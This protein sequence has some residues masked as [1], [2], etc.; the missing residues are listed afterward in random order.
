MR[1]LDRYL[2]RELLI[3]LGYCLSG[4]LIFWVSFDLFSELAEFQERRM[5]FREIGEYYVVKLPELLVVVVPIALLLALLY[6]L[7]NHARHNELVA[8]RAA[9]ISLWRLS[10][11][12]LVVGVLFTSAL[13]VVNEVWVPRSAEAVDAILR[14]KGSLKAGA[15][16]WHSNLIFRNARDGRTWSIGRFNLDTFEM[17]SPHVAWELPDGV[18]RS[19]SAATA[20][21]T[22]GVWV[23]QKVQEIT[24]PPVG[25]VDA[26][27]GRT[28]DFSPK[29]TWY[30]DLA[31]PEFSETPDQIKS[32][33]KISRLTTV[34][35]AKE[36]QLSMGE[37]SNY[38]RLHPH[39]NRMDHALLH[40]QLQA[41]LAWP[42]TCL[43][44]VLI[45]LPF[46]AASGRRNV[47]VGVASS[48]FICFAFFILLRFGL[49]LGTSGRVPPWLAAWLPNAL[50][51]AIGVG[52]TSRV[53]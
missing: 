7:T 42:W 40:T 12:Y 28:N 34:Q 2:L 27:T 18:R 16:R 17:Q 51:A 31:V 14:R 35:A 44:V 50:F 36:P 19:L 20:I 43:V 32:E 41:R 9:G 23:F 53:R 3:P 26:T 39:L 10:A 45:A 37:I 8:I 11:P 49:T 1:L 47:F 6:S 15:D 48:I 33:I 46:G 30:S 38:L 21:R 29:S 25:K 22:N 13:Y 24:Y 5:G 52:L 4:F